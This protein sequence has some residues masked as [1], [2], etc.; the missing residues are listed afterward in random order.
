MCKIISISGSHGVGKTSLLNLIVKNP[1]F[2]EG[3]IKFFS[4]FNSGLFNMGFPLN[5]EAY[6]F[7]EVMFSQSKAF[8]LGYETIKYYLDRRYD[9]RLILTDRS[10]LDTYIYTDYFLKKHSEHMD[11]YSSLLKEMQ[12][13][14]KEVLNEINHI[15]LPPF[16]DFE[17][18]EDRMSLLDRD[19]IWNNFNTHF[20][21][22][23]NDKVIVLSSNTTQER[24]EEIIDLINKLI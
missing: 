3:R 13:K 22:P 1:D 18:L 6:D 23:K 2:Q 8:S 15:I 14:S 17:I 24:Y 5:G 7:D 16:K 11:K 21:N 10:C 20:L 19:N 4:E 9:K 12:E